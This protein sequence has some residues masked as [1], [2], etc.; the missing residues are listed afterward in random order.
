M[1]QPGPPQHVLR[2][3]NARDVLSP[4]IGTTLLTV[5]RNRPNQVLE[6]RGNDVI[7]GTPRTPSGS[8]VPIA[9]VDA[10]L[11]RLIAES[12][13]EIS[14]P[15]LGHRRTSFVGAALMTLDGVEMTD[16]SPPR[17]VISNPAAAEERAH[18]L[19]LWA[20]LIAEGETRGVAPRRLRE[21]GIYGGAQGI[22][23]DKVRT[24]AIHH[25]GVTV[26]VLHTGSSYADDL[27][28]DGVRY[29]Y[30]T[31]GR[32]AGRDAAE[33][34]ST[35]AAKRL[36]L[37][38]FVISYPSPGSSVRNVN[39]AW[40]E[41]WDDAERQFLI[42]YGEQ[43]PP[44]TPGVDELDAQPFELTEKRA[45]SQA[46]TNIR[47]GQHRFKFKVFQAYG[48]RCAV[49]DLDVETLLDAAHLR[50]YRDDGTN[51]RRNGLVLCSIHHRAFDAALFGIE[52]GTLALVPR[53]SGPTA[54]NLRITRTTL[55]HLQR[56]PHAAA[57]DWRWKIWK[58]RTT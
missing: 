30:P 47:Q 13:L 51:D 18:R 35:K 53:N 49:C 19:G 26:A 25:A 2:V 32:A 36:Q 34:D 17:L 10:A 58:A 39:L 8:A 46:L 52:P 20:A 54:K 21:L 50:E 57:I 55:S 12:E 31:T 45:K 43:P 33:V 42:T 1:T 15:S 56:K 29:H 24:Q 14:V 40:I 9:Y 37:P 28:D 3:S 27:Y 16:S 7:V 6:L 22:W 11:T 48:A 5:P 23:V 38:V 41:A 44:A 4:L